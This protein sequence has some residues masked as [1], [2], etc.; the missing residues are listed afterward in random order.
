MN[1]LTTIIEQLKEQNYLQR[2][3]AARH[4][5][6]M[7]RGNFSVKEVIKHLLELLKD[8]VS[9]VRQ[10]AIATLGKIGTEDELPELIAL[11]QYPNVDE[12]WTAVVALGE[13]GSSNALDDLVKCLQEDPIWQIRR[14]AVQAIYNIGGQRAID[15][16]NQ[17]AINDVNSVVRRTAITASEKLSQEQ[18]NRAVWAIKDW[19]KGRI[20]EP[21][22]SSGY[23]LCL[24]SSGTSMGGENRQYIVIKSLQ[25][26]G[27]KYK[28]Q[29][30]STPEIGENCYLF[31]LHN[32]VPGRKIPGGFK[33]RLVT[34]NNEGWDGN[35]D[36]A[37]EAKD[38]LRVLVTVDP[39]DQI[40]WETAP[41]P[42]DYS[43]QPLQF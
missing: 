32:T 35:E 21:G 1:D 13:I 43:P 10:E 6:R 5:S 9:E 11:L 19:L 27:Q 30:M 40:I 38:Y 42:D 28:L 2:E 20:S 29:I 41:L 34:E 16:L 15:I 8:P 33:L 26:A 23:E 14:A 39:G 4:L 25:I 22:L 24:S 37:K 31:E 18:K 17:C 3:E 12:R 7:E 36:E